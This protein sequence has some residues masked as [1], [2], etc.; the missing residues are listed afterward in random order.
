MI[1]HLKGS[2]KKR[3]CS[4]WK[5]ISKISSSMMISKCT[6]Y[7]HT[8]NETDPL[9]EPD[10]LASTGRSVFPFDMT[11]I[12]AIFVAEQRY[13]Q[14]WIFFA[15]TKQTMLIYSFISINIRRGTCIPNLMAGQFLTSLWEL[16]SAKSKILW[17]IKEFHF[18]EN[19][20]YV[21]LW[22]KHSHSFRTWQQK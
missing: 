2:V 19:L 17:K 7:T 8:S 16:Q 12:S 9:S 5:R 15:I 22:T 3:S 10:P 14:S 4:I 21:L 1:D 13:S 18:I 20:E 11:T 6:T